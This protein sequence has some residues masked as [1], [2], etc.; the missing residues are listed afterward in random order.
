MKWEVRTMRSGTSFFNW[1]VFKKLVCRF[2][3]LWGLYGVIWLVVLPLNGLLMLRMD[4]MTS[5][6]NDLSS[7]IE[8][9]AWQ[10][11]PGTASLVLSL[12][13]VFGVLSAMAVLSHLYNPR[14]ANF[15]GSLPVRR[16]ALF[17]THYL[18]GLAFLLVP[19]AVIFL[20]T[21]LIE[22]AGGHLCLTGLLFWL[23]AGCGEC[24]LFYS[25]AVFCGMFTGHI[26]ALPV[27]YGVFNAIAAALTGLF[28]VVMQVFYYGYAG[29]GDWL[30]AAARWL[31][32]VWE[33]SDSVRAAVRYADVEMEG[34]IVGVPD[35]LELS[36]L[37]ALGIYALIA[38][39]MA[40]GSFFLYRFRRLESAGDVVS[41]KCMRPVFRY[42]VAVMAGLC[43]GFVTC[44]FLGGGEIVLM[45]SIVV[46][47]VIGCFAAQMLLDKSFRVFKKW[48]GALAVGL[49]FVLLFVVVE[50]DLTGYE[51][52][53]PDPARVEAVE[54]SG[55][56]WGW[57]N[58]SGDYIRLTVE[59]PEQIAMF[60]DL[61]RAAVE[62]R[63]ADWSSFRDG[64]RSASFT[65]VYHLDGGGT[66]SRRYSVTIDAAQAG[67]EG[68]AAWA[69]QRVFDDRDLYWRV[70]GFD[71]L[72][73]VLANG[74][75]L[76]SA[77]FYYRNYD[78]E[79]G[80][81]YYVEDPDGYFY[82]A[83][84]QALLDAVLE[85]FAAGRIGTRSVDKN[86][87]YYYDPDRYERSLTFTAER[88][89]QAWT[90]SV[91]VP[92]GAASTLAAL[93]KLGDSGG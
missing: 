47:A 32:P 8:S 53:V 78:E 88:G 4:S 34:V 61:H 70:Y 44:S 26:L 1:P 59:D 57:Y 69:L 41:V 49:A 9:F 5:R 68:T 46:W 20:L 48:R 19:N 22:L 30:E 60:V 54:V 23:A 64:S 12:A 62:Q 33:L 51:T 18:A 85:D 21:L 80:D 10:T 84:A 63:D 31:T 17:L 43:F 83:D 67:T 65:L 74:G 81:Y 75:R 28:T 13:V 77:R 42:G 87:G 82:G 89:D 25:M 55:L 38:L 29:P 24:F 11:V 56:Q 6:W 50:L 16:E 7:Y 36:G 92:D 39:A 2:W 15:F 72:E 3:P 58:D 90:V 86:S 73:E 52:R 37:G 14:S 93:E 40:A 66:L 79:Y 76:S 35:R 45:V 27:F 91:F 71:T